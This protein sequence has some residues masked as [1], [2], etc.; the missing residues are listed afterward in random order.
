MTYRPKPL[1]IFAVKLH[2]DRLE[3]REQLAKNSGQPVNGTKW[4]KPRF[5]LTVQ[6]HARWENFHDRT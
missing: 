5:R 3:L 2:D 6:A 1:N 4:P